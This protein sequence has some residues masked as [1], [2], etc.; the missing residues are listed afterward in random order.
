M[1]LT[2]KRAKALARRREAITQEL[3]RR[4]TWEQVAGGTVLWIL[5][6]F[7]MAFLAGLRSPDLTAPAALIEV[8]LSVL[9]FSLIWWLSDF[10]H[11]FW[12]IVPVAVAACAG[13]VAAQGIVG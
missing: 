3:H 2:K 13:F 4:I 12:I 5:W 10:R 9:G 6:G 7:V 11:R 1:M 8:V